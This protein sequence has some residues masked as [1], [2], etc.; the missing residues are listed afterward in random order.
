M[1]AHFGWTDLPIRSLN[2]L[3]HFSTRFP[4]QPCVANSVG[5]ELMEDQKSYALVID[6]PGVASDD[7]E[8][9][10]SDR[11]F[12]LVL[13]S[14]SDVPTDAEPLSIERST[15]E[16]N[17]SGRFRLPI[18]VDRVTATLEQGVLSLVFPKVAALQPK[19]ITINTH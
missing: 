8:L 2:G 16:R 15:T 5:S 11:T 4:S 12:W 19:R 9:T 17:T 7:I 3:R 10:V 6:V 1:Y 18:D 14:H 13:R